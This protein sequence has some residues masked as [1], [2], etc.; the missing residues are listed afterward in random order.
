MRG[1]GSTTTPSSI[2]PRARKVEDAISP[3]NSKVI[4]GTK[5]EDLNK[6]ASIYGFG[7]DVPKSIIGNEEASVN[8]I[9]D[10]MH[11]K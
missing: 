6:V 10:K 5:I 1:Y 11:E 8:N 2:S 9:I 3:N 4:R 7:F